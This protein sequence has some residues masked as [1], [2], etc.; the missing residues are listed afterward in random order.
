MDTKKNIWSNQNGSKIGEIK[1]ISVLTKGFA[2]SEA[3][4]PFVVLAGR[5]ACSV[6]EKSAFFGQ[7]NI[8]TSIEPPMHCMIVN[9]YLPFFLAKNV[10]AVYIYTTACREAK[11]PNF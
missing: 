7:Y 9:H 3:P 10:E 8:T 5:L 2:L 4:F 11:K 6:K 1:S